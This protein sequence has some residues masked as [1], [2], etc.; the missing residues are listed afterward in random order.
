[1]SALAEQQ[2]CVTQQAVRASLRRQVVGPAGGGQGGLVGGEKVLPV[3]VAVQEGSHGPGQLPG[4]GVQYVPHVPQIDSSACYSRSCLYEP[5][6]APN[7]GS[8]ADPSVR[9]HHG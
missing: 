8:G 9:V 4:V 3:A 1:M 5:Q 6:A 2:V 7:G